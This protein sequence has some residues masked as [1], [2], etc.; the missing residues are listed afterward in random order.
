MGC[1]VKPGN[2]EVKFCLPQ[3]RHCEERSDE[4]IQLPAQAS[5]LLR[6]ARNDEMKAFSV[7]P[8]SQ[9]AKKEGRP[10]LLLAGPAH[11]LAVLPTGRTYF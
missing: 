10:G 11:P 8:A 9:G 4:A 7:V 6:C 2:D 5:G 3:F 1:R